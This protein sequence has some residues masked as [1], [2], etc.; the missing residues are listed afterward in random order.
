MLTEALPYIKQYNGKI[1]VI[2]YGGHAMTEE[3]LKKRPHHS[4]FIKI[5]A[6]KAGI[7]CIRTA[8]N[9]STFQPCAASFAYSPCRSKA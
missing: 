5:C 6:D 7:A 4:Y 2:K 1:V 3:S 9:Y 8:C